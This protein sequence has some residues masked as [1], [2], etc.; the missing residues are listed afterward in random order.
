MHD[1]RLTT[2]LLFPAAEQDIPEPSF[3][4]GNTAKK[5]P[6]NGLH[7]QSSNLT[8]GTPNRHASDPL[9]QHQHR[10][11]QQLEQQQQ[12]LFVR[13]QMHDA[14]QTARFYSPAEQHILESSFSHD[15]TGKRLLAKSA[16]Q[17]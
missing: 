14:R 1:A 11:Q 4:H 13:M 3:S 7:S 5:L 10:G 2:A 8:V 17:W 15:Y 9:N 6:V 16:S 12:H